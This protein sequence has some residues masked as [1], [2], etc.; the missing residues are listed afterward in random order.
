MDV[1]KLIEITGREEDLALIKQFNDKFSDASYNNKSKLGLS[2]EEFEQ[3]WRVVM[4]VLQQQQLAPAVASSYLTLIKILSR[5]KLSVCEV[6]SEEHMNTII[7]LA[8]LGDS[9]QLQNNEHQGCASEACHCLSNLVYQSSEAQRVFCTTQLVQRLL[10]K[11]QQPQQLEHDLNITYVRLLFLVTALEQHTRMSAVVDHDA[12]TTLL[13]LLDD[14]AASAGD[15]KA[16]T[17]QREAVE[18]IVEVLKVLY[19]LCVGLTSPG[20]CSNDQQQRLDT[21][22]V[23]DTALQPRHDQSIVAIV[24]RVRELLLSTAHTHQ[25]TQLMHSHCINLLVCVPTTALSTL[26]PSLSEGSS[27]WWGG[28]SGSAKSQQ[29][30]KRLTVYRNTDMTALVQILAFLHARLNAAEQQSSEKVTPVMTMLVTACESSR[31]IRRFV[32]LRVMP[33][34]RDVSQRPEE[35]N[36]LRSKL[37]KLMTSPVLEL[38]HL[39]ATLLYILCNKSVDRLIKYTGYGNCAGL[40]AS[41]GLLAGGPVKGGASASDDD[42]SSEE[43]D[44][45]EYEKV[46][47]MVNPVT[48]CYEPVRPNPV[49]EMSEEQKEYEAVKLVNALD[50]LIRS[51]SIKPCSVGADGQPQPLESVLQL[52]EA[53]GVGGFQRPTPAA[54]A[55]DDDHDK[56]DDE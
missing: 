13:P 32:R 7:Q 30:Q 51:G 21:T 25:H 17:M 40:L 45:E 42:S 23:A 55:D 53:G 29:Q 2:A 52:Q 26:T 27:S 50:K 12:L 48:G 14:T 31:T 36:S 38:K 5:D 44:T 10:T 19:S 4:K 37:V 56:S 16:P 35:G 8:A 28:G 39:S 54:A 24:D 15:N 22:M 20:S 47:H 49:D 46:K 33:P 41:L 43:S 11:L 6:L 9:S 1:N 18:R 3:L 34:L